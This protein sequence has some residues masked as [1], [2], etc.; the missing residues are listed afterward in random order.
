MFLHALNVFFNTN[1]S[2]KLNEINFG[3]ARLYIVNE[4]EYFYAIVV[5]FD[6]YI[7]L[8][9][10]SPIHSL[11]RGILDQMVELVST[12]TDDLDLLSDSDLEL[13]VDNFIFKAKYQLI[14]GF[15]TQI[16]S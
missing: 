6:E 3:N 9:E 13:M 11:S 5:N 14:D 4:E 10:D 1:F 2:E 8:R 7:D 16:D 12:L 15:R